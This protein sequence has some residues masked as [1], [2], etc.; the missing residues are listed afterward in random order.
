MNHFV[1]V[2]WDTER[3]VHLL[4]LKVYDF[5]F[6]FLL[7]TSI[8]IHWTV[9]GKED[10]DELAR[11][12]FKANTIPMSPY[13]NDE[14]KTL[15]HSPPSSTQTYKILFELRLSTVPNL[16][17]LEPWFSLLTRDRFEFLKICMHICIYEKTNN[18]W[19]LSE[20]KTIWIL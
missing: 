9:W 18:T 5:S 16:I 1:V 15:G 10:R 17:K 4:T 6:V 7:S 13:L 11:L 2:I 3:G 12:F 20:K 8:C 19:R 14:H